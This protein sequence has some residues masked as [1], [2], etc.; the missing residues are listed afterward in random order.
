MKRIYING[1]VYKNEKH[2]SH[3]EFRDKS[4][5]ANIYKRSYMSSKEKSEIN[6]YLN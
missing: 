1:A 2:V 6:Q 4:E 5:N 3:Y